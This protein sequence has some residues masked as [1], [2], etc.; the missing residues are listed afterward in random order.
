MR[1][2]KVFSPLTSTVYRCELPQCPVCHGQLF[3]C[4]YRSHYKT[5]QQL[6]GAH[7]IAYQPSRCLSP[8]CKACGQP[9]RSAEWLQIAPPG[10]TYGYDVIAAIGWRRQEYCMTFHEVH[11]QISTTVQICESQVRYL[12]TQQYLPLLACCERAQIKRLREVSEHGGVLL[13]LDGLAPEGGEA[14]L[15]V[16]RELRTGLTLRSGW[17]S[18][19]DQAAFENFLRPIPE[20]GFQVQVV[21]SDKQRGLVPAVGTV[22]PH[23]KHA[24]CQPHYVKN[25]AEPIAAAD[26][27][28]KVALRKSVRRAIGPMIRSEHVEQPGILTVTGLLPSPVESALPPVTTEQS[29]SHTPSADRHGAD[30]T[31]TTKE[32]GEDGK[33]DRGSAATAFDAI[34]TDLQQ[35]IRYLL[36]LK[37][38]PP[39][40]LAG[41]EMYDRL[42]EV[43]QCLTAMMELHSDPRVR[44]LQHGLE[45]ALSDVNGAYLD[46]RQAADWLHAIS[47]IL[48]PEQHPK[49][50]GEMVRQELCDDVEHLVNHTR[51]HPRLVEFATQIHKTTDNYAQGLFY[52][53]DIEDLPRSNNARESE[54]R[55]MTRQLLR[56]TGQKGATRRLIL[57]SG[58]WEAIPHPGTLEQT[59]KAISDVAPEALQQERTRVD[60]HRKRFRT[61][62]RSGK[63]SRAQLQEFLEQWRRLAHND[64]AG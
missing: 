35:K 31:P 28:M 39:F 58:A 6:N 56:R 24:L 36:T 10:G 38:R 51:D 18:Q 21:L 4:E 33:P 40:R 23:A 61:H 41:I 54:F 63:Q 32:G 17:M 11:Q 25:L 49:R 12:Y 27:A 37:G 15:W 9:L 29:V 22:F 62:T 16:V 48:D 1:T 46:V 20:A 14:Q 26:N 44:Q 57:R 34:V 13:S 53:Y 3:G 55:D 30:A 43:K 2:S 64:R 5:V 59:V 45:Q 42:D 52:T 8:D 50:T 19:Q 47:R 7:R 60:M